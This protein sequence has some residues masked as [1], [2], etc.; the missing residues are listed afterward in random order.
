MAVA[1]TNYRFVYVDI[2]SYGRLILQFLNDL[3]YGYQ[4][5]QICSNY[6]VTDLFQEQKV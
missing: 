6:P 2:G 5:R 1:E 4:F 3:R